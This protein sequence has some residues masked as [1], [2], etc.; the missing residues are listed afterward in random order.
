M[1][2]DAGLILP[3]IKILGYDK[4]SPEQERVRNDPMMSD[5]VNR[6]KSL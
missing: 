1:Q 3:M 2:E 5:L 6:S 4:E